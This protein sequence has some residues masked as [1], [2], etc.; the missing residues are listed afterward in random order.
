M[1]ARPADAVSPH[2]P[3]LSLSLSLAPPPPRPP[4][5]SRRAA[6]VT[7]RHQDGG[8]AFLWHL[9]GREAAFQ[10]AWKEKTNCART[11]TAATVLAP[12]AAAL[13]AQRES[14]CIPERMTQVALQDSVSTKLRNLFK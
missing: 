7:K 6:G 1:R 8:R 10:A 11:R 5:T 9:H 3:R 12:I 13:L 4:P 2:T 14:L